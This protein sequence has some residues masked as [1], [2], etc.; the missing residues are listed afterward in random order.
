MRLSAL[1]QTRGDSRKRPLIE[2][3]DRGPRPS[4]GN[5]RFYRRALRYTYLPKYSTAVCIVLKTP[6]C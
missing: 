4:G 1:I 6:C 3:R 5:A 2:R